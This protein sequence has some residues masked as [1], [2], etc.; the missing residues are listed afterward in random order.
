MVTSFISMSDEKD[1]IDWEWTGGRDNKF[2]QT[3]YF[4][5]GNLDYT[6]SFYSDTWSLTSQT[7]HDY[8]VEWTK[9]AIKWGIDGKVVRTLTASS[10]PPGS[11]P[12]TPS[13]IQFAVWHGGDSPN[14]GTSNW[15]G[16]R[17]D[18]NAPK[19]QFTAVFDYVSIQWYD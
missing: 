4:I 13:R 6:K 8:T 18:W 3:N 2:G 16:G 7:Y 5:K 11:Y 17:I 14:F 10:Q 19:T 1:E 9:D 15:A 12:N